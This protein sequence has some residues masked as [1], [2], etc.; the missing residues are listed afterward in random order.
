MKD[1]VNVMISKD[2]WHN[3]KGAPSSEVLTILLKSLGISN[4]INN[5]E[6]GVCDTC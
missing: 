1:Q 6:Y 2:L 4:T 3:P 5:S